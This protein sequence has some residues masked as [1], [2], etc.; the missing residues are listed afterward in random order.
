MALRNT[1]LASGAAL[2]AFAATSAHAIT[3]DG[4]EFEAGVIVS[5]GAII[6]IEGSSTSTLNDLIVAGLAGTADG[7]GRVDSIANQ[8]DF[9]AD[10]QS[11]DNNAFLEFT[12]G[13][14]GFTN[15]EDEFGNAGIGNIDVGEDFSFQLTA[16]LGDELMFI[17]SDLPGLTNPNNWLTYSLRTDGAGIGGSGV[18]DFDD[19]NAVWTYSIEL[20]NLLFDV[21]GG[22]AFAN[23]DTNGRAGGSDLVTDVTFNYECGAVPGTFADC[24]LTDFSFQTG[25]TNTRTAAIPTPASA[26]LLGLG[27]LGF[28]VAARR[29]RG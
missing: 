13:D 7:R 6:E 29:R 1:I 14:F 21:T 9:V 17:S 3:I 4:I 22:L 20:N 23:F 25:S 15:L 28:G 11:G 10:W 18:A 26:A 12:F 8:G 19:D 24:L 2:A 27:L 16:G 5:Q